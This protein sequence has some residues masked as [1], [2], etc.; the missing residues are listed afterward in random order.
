M[1]LRRVLVA[2]DLSEGAGAAVRRAANLAAAH[3]AELTVLSVLPPSLAQDL[4]TFAGHAFDG[5]VATHA[6][7]WADVRLRTGPVSGT[8]L[9]EAADLAADLLVLGANGDRGFAGAF[10]GHTTANVAHASGCPVL[11]VRTPVNDASDYA[12][13]L[14]AVDDS[15]EARRAAEFGMA[16]TPS[17][18]HIVAHVS[19]VIGE[20]LLRLRG[21]GESDIDDLREASL[22]EIRPRI[23]AFAARLDPRPDTVVVGP[24]TPQRALPELASRYRADLVVTGSGSSTRFERVLLGGVAQS[25]LRHVRS[26]V[27][28]VR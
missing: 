20:H 9:A 21:L 26:D 17:A 23:E 12:T 14:L 28:I 11:V 5:H 16:L 18:V 27:L 3:G 22:A 13:V 15:D 25:V 7:A 24:G 4:S 1:R 19:V 8:I 10:V 2:T 6:P